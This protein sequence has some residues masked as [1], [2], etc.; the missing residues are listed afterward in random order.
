MSRSVKQ[1]YEK[2][3]NP[4]NT[5]ILGPRK[6]YRITQCRCKYC[7]NNP[8]S[9]RHY[10]IC[11]PEGPIHHTVTTWRVALFDVLELMNRGRGL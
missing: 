8:F 4:G 1:D 3:K 6:P 7:S 2:A 9:V 11:F 5:R 10:N